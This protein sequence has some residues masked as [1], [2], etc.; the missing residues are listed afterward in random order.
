M[1]PPP[2][3]LA[4]AASLAQRALTRNA[5]RPTA[6]R[7]AAAGVI[8]AG[9]GALSATAAR[10]FRRRGTTLNPVDPTRA[11]VLVT[12][13]PNAISR[14]PMYAGL[15][16]MLVANAVRRGSWRALLPVA[17]FTLVV[18]RVQIA[19]EEAALLARFG[20]DYKVYCAAV[21]RWLG[22]RSLPR[23]RD[24]V[25]AGDGVAHVAEPTPRV[26]RREVKAR[27]PGGTGVS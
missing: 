16:G 23:C 17:A 25:L 26:M 14:N 20:D 12:T 5:P 1:R 24:R 11:S 2:P 8:A 7:A 13:G 3:V 19:A 10:Q 22:L 6:G 21:P 27:P 18:D 9:S 15:A 4:F